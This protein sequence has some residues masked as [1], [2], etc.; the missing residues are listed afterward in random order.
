MYIKVVSDLHIEFGEPFE[1]IESPDDMDTVLILAGD[2]H[3]AAFFEAWVRDLIVS[4]NFKAYII[5]PGNHEYYGQDFAEL[6]CDFYDFSEELLEFGNVYFNPS[7]DRVI[8]E[9]TTF[10]FGPMW[11]DGGRTKKSKEAVSRGLNDFRVISLDGHRFTV[12]DSVDI[13]TSF[14]QDL[15]SCLRV[16]TTENVV[17]VTHHLPTWQAISSYFISTSDINGG[18]A[19]N[20]D[21]Y[22]PIELLEK[23]DVMCFGHTHE[24]VLRKMVFLGGSK[25]IQMICNPRGYPGETHGKFDPELLFDLDMMD[26]VKKEYTWP[27]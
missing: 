23:I 15:K 3:C 7:F 25:E 10:I 13:F 4:T 24:Q 21:D 19:S 20:L 1:I 11:T 16:V 12:D 26:F 18:F 17:L 27:E 9:D 6:T 22:I 2:L 14:I 5:I 8:I